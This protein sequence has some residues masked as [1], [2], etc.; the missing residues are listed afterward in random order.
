MSTA[1]VTQTGGAA[2]VAV[3][4]SRGLQGVQGIQGATG[5]TGAQGD[6]A[7]LKYTFD[8]QTG[9]GAPS[10]GHLKFNSST[11][12]AVTRI[13]IRDTD[14]DGSNTSAL[15]ALI[16]DSTSTIKARVVIRSNS[17]ADASHFNF[18]VTSVTDE[19]NHHHINGTYVSG[20][21]FTANE[22]VT[23]DFYQTGDKGEQGIQGI[24]GVPGEPGDITASQIT[25]STA[26]GRSL[27]TAA[28]AAAQRTSLGLGT[29]AT[30]ASTDYVGLTG[31]QTIAGNKTFSGDMSFSSTTRPTS[32]GT[33]TPAATS[34]ITETDRRAQEVADLSNVYYRQIMGHESGIWGTV[35]ISATNLPD[36]NG[37]AGCR[38]IGTTGLSSASAQG[39]GIRYPDGFISGSATFGFQLSFDTRFLFRNALS[40]ILDVAHFFSVRT[41]STFWSA[42]SIGLYHVAQPAATWAAT[43]S[44]VVGN[45]I[46][47]SGIVYV[48]STLG[49]S[50]ASQPTFNATING[51]TNDGTAV[52]RTLGPHTSNNWAL[53]FVDASSNITLT[54]TGVAWVAGS[55]NTTAL[56]LRSNGSSIFASVNGSTEVSVSRGALTQ[57]TPYIMCRGESA[58]TSRISGLIWTVES[59]NI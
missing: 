50:G 39:G 29:A 30:T 22:I 59:A 27:L 40:A 57:A 32:G 55:N 38:F 31:N 25:D 9:A 45:R 20:S 28:D 24:Q 53:A 7:G 1:S 18:L 47:V 6:R 4:V 41:S 15:L 52:W 13:S 35:G 3:T 48:C 46:N 21:A 26:A 42:S 56:R 49:I 37:R 19:G 17:N 16:D 23:F 11:L 8:D 34:L 5:A 36:G 2:T 10:P 51:S 54:D 43:T 14:F 33:G 58:T 44:Y 12:S